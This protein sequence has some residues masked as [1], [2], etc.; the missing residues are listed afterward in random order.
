MLC[1]ALAATTGNCTFE[2]D[3]CGWKNGGRSKWHRGKST[4]SS[5]TGASR[6]QSGSYFVYLETSSP[7]TKGWQS[8]L[9]HPVASGDTWSVTFHYHMHGATMGTLRLDA[10]VGGKWKPLWSKT[11]QQQKNQGDSFAQAKARYT[12]VALPPRAAVGGTLCALSWR[13]CAAVLC[14][15]DGRQHPHACASA[16]SQQ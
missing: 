15:W 2:Q 3:L 12:A 4:P 8:S 7:S 5:S 14:A 13:F 6:A 1:A 16:L 9:T 10:Y 11:G